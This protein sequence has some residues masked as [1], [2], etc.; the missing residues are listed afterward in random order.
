[1]KKHVENQ[2]PVFVNLALFIILRDNVCPSSITPSF[3]YISYYKTV[4]F[5]NPVL[6]GFC[7]EN[8]NLSIL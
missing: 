7:L 1:M 4:V 5:E 2:F 6:H 8:S 3:C